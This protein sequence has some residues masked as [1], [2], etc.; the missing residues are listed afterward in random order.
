M[1]K[2]LKLENHSIRNI[3]VTIVKTLVLVKIRKQIV[4]IL[5]VNIVVRNLNLKFLVNEYIV[6]RI[7]F[8]MLKKQVLLK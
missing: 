4:K 3:V 1:E 2:N 8:G 5:F 7:V 6:V